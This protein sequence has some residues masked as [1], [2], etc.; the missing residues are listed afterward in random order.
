MREH[1]GQV[2]RNLSVVLKGPAVLASL[3]EAYIDRSKVTPIAQSCGSLIGE[4]HFKIRIAAGAH[5]IEAGKVARLPVEVRL[6]S[7][8]S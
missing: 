4:H 7:G 8:R 6:F 5:V 3:S 2:S 1:G